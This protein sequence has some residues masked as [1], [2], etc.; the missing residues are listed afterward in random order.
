[1]SIFDSGTLSESKAFNIPAFSASVNMICEAVSMIPVKLYQTEETE[2]GR[3]TTEIN[4]YRT[5]LINDDTGDTL[6]GVEFKRAMI[7]DYLVHGNSYAFINRKSGKIRQ[8]QELKLRLGR[9]YF[10]AFKLRSDFQR[11][12]YFSSRKNIFAARIH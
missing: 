7:R 2:K 9:Q 12:Q 3:V 5:D 8:N 1:M 10:G 6:S 11:L 4:D